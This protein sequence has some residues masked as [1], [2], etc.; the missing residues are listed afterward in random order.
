MELLRVRGSIPGVITRRYPVELH[1]LRE[2]LHAD[3]V[4][5]FDAVLHLG[6]APESHNCTWKLSP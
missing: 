3:L 4:R 1:A 5:G 2:R 6:Q